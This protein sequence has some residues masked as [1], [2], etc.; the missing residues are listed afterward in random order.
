MAN[1]DQVLSNIFSPRFF[2]ST[3]S[4]SYSRR[5]KKS[6]L[7]QLIDAAQHNR[8]YSWGALPLTL[9]LRTIYVI[10]L[11]PQIYPIYKLLQHQHNS[12]CYFNR[13]D[14][15]SQTNT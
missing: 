8:K 13:N 7:Q 4:R 15:L 5:N 9:L 6:S 1:I 11:L 12:Y 10:S 2:N 3:T 14:L